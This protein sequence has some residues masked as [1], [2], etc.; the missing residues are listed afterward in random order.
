MSRSI[1]ALV[2]CAGAAASAGGPFVYSQAVREGDFYAGANV[3][4]IDNLTINNNGDWLVEV[5]TDGVD[6]D[7]D[8]A[9]IRSFSLFVQ[10]GD[11]LTAP[12]GA[13]VDSFDSVTLNNNGDA[14]FNFFL[15]G[16]SGSSDDSGVFFNTTLVQ[17]EGTLSTSPGFSPGTP[18]IGYF[19]ATINDANQ[20]LLVASVDDPNIPSSV[21]RG[22]VLLDYNAGAGTYTELVLVKEG[23]ILNG[24]A[25]LDVSTS[26]HEIAFNNNGDVLFL[27]D[28]DTGSSANDFHLYRNGDLLLREGDAF[29]GETIEF[30]DRPL[31]M[32][33]SGE[34]VIKANLTGDTG[35]DDVIIKNGSV[36]VQEG[37]AA[38]GAL[39]AFT[40]ESIGS[41]SGP[42]EIDNLGNVLWYGEWSD[43]NADIDSGLFLN[44]VLVVQ[45]GVTVIDGLIVDTIANGQDAFHLSDNGRWIIFEATLV[46]GIDGAFI[47]R[48][49]APGG[50]A[51]L[52]AGG[53]MGLR[54]RR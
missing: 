26:E 41:T 34:W 2:L 7:K 28:L 45:E 9:I 25:L 36:F 27:A 24:F 10:E 20:I 4:R 12:A 8:G 13:S 32:N 48:V 43:P 39:G 14:G 1:V 53:L 38:P 11:S 46:G 42:V 3:T 21:D 30:L 19:S 29:A 22:L 5:D 18:Y 52:A 31:D 51:L 35:M 23:D 37:T 6:T 47:V 54:R 49:P 50:A 15:D 17:Q 44:D 16:T 40:L 33:D